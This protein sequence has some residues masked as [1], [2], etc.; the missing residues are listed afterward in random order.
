[1]E[2]IVDTHAHLDGEEF[3][4]DIDEVIERAKSQGIE[5]FSFRLSTPKASIVCRLCVGG[6]LA[7]STR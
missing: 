2:N 1:M 4:S 6:I 5:R 3:V 7:I